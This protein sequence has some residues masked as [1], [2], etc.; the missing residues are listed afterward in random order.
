MTNLRFEPAILV[1]L[2]DTTVHIEL[3][4]LI[5]PWA[6]PPS[7]SAPYQTT[8]MRYNMHIVLASSLKQIEPIVHVVTV[9]RGIMVVG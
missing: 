6:K 2:G 5:Q 9:D 8:C 1:R 7:P 3:W 4:L